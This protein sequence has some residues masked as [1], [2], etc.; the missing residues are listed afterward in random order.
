MESQC[1][2]KSDRIDNTGEKGG[3]SSLL[4]SSSSSPP[5]PPPLWNLR[6][7]MYRTKFLAMCW[8]HDQTG[9]EVFTIPDEVRGHKRE[10]RH[11]V[12]KAILEHMYVFEYVFPCPLILLRC[13]SDMY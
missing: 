11:D 7:R 1:W 2:R 5:P 10:R 9:Q 3:L 12:S 8:V 6:C 13:L 4:S